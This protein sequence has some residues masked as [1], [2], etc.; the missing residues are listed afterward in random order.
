MFTELN[1]RGL[2]LRL[3]IAFNEWRIA[4]NEAKIAAL[5]AA[6][7]A[8]FKERWGFDRPDLT[9]DGMTLGPRA[10][11]DFDHQA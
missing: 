4:R 2:Y 6:A 7:N 10:D 8:R 3:R 1:L 5:K 9:D 11:V